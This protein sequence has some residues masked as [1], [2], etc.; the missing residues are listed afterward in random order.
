MNGELLCGVLSPYTKYMLLHRKVL[1]EAQR[2]YNK[3]CDSKDDYL[4]IA[5]RTDIP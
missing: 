5:G 3:I 4:K 1:K 2:L